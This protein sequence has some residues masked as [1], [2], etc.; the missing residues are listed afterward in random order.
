MSTAVQRARSRIRLHGCGK[1]ENPLTSRVFAN[2]RRLGYKLAT[3]PLRHSAA[4][5]VGQGTKLAPN[6]HVVRLVPVLGRSFVAIRE[7]S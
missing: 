1:G 6:G 3:S 5:I 7:R 4:G 2:I